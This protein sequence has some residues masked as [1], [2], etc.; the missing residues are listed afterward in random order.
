MDIFSIFHTVP[1][2]RFITVDT[3]EMEELRFSST[4]FLTVSIFSSIIL[5][6]GGPGSLEGETLPEAI[7]MLITLEKA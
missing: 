6:L 5:V 3:S 2:Y 1:V 4:R 7:N